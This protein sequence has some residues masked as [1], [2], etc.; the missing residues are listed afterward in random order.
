[1]LVDIRI[2]LQVLLEHVDR[3]FKI[4]LLVLVL[5]LDLAVHLDLRHG[6]VAEFVLEVGGV[7]DQFFLVLDQLGGLV[8]GVLEG[9]DPVALEGDPGPLVGDL[10]LELLL[11][12]EED[13]HELGQ[14]SVQRVEVL[15]LLVHLVGLG[16]HLGDFLLP[17]GDVLL[18][19]LDLVVEDVFEFFQFLGLLLEFVDL[20]LVGI[21]GLISLLDDL[22]LLLDLPL[23]LR[24][25]RLQSLY[26]VV[27]LPLLLDILLLF[28]LFL[29]N[30]LLGN[31]DLAFGSE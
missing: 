17:R 25:G 6:L 28:L 24:V 29:G 2:L 23:K 16:L 12:L 26:L 1:M 20:A 8:E 7:G 31:G 13:C 4:F 18:E 19:L 9:L 3:F 30:L 27:V 11:V 21:D 10:A 22:S 5:L 14:G 15:E